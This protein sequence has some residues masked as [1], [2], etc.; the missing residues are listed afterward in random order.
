M[1]SDKLDAVVVGSGPN[2]LAAAIT[3]AREGLSVL[4]LEGDEDV[5]GGLRSDEL[6]LPGF[7][8]DICASVHA[9]GVV[10]PFF[11]SMDLNRHGLTWVRSPAALAHPLDDGSAVLLR[12]GMKG[13]DENLGA[14]SE[15]FGRLMRL[16]LRDWESLMEQLLGSPRIPRHPLLLARFGLK[17]I[18]SASALAK[19]H[20]RGREA[21]ALF[22]G[23]AAH[24]V[25][26]L[27]RPGSAAVGL[28]LGAAAIKGGWPLARGGS[29]SLA[30]ALEKYLRSLGGEIRTGCWVR[31]YKDIPK[32]RAVLFDLTPRNLAEV[33]GGLFP[34]G[35][36]RRLEA[37]ALGPGAFKMDW[38]LSEPIPWKAKE[39]LEAATVHVGG[40]LEEIAESE[41]CVWQGKAPERP[42]VILVQPTLFDSGRAP[43]GMHVAWAYC[44]VPNG[45]TED[46][47]HR[48]ESQ[49]ERFAPGFRETILARCVWTPQRLEEHNPNYVGGDFLGGSQDPRRLFLR[50]LGRWVPYRTPLKGYYICSSS[51]P[52]GGGVHGMCGHNAAQLVLKDVFR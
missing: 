3:L 11:K 52:P 26:P 43:R 19:A 40:T 17:A 15:A 36:L 39:C 41:R 1:A 7:V 25:L 22:A 9:L 35:Y 45:S 24:S 34:T 29:S 50:P 14:D 4:V 51:M 49:I 46:M 37:H 27:E 47:V 21:Q 2:G 32:A 30:N 8:H 48:I 12:Q 18:C 33:G 13:V 10:S 6:T 23:L 5:G 42:F 44:H 16:V 28:I 38:A 20:F 31:S